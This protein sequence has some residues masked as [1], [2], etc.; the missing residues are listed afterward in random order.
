MVQFGI[1]GHINITS[2]VLQGVN[3]NIIHAPDQLNIFRIT[4]QIKHLNTC[5]LMKW[6]LAHSKQ[7]M[8]IE[9]ADYECADQVTKNGTQNFKIH[10][11]NSILD[12]EIQ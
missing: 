4:E 11:F 9:N 6:K 5:C 3:L 10:F 12:N 7:R 2:E 8:P 1:L